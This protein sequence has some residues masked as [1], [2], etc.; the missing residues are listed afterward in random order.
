MHIHNSALLDAWYT[1]ITIIE[2]IIYNLYTSVAFGCSA[3]RTLVALSLQDDI[4]VPMRIMRRS[5]VTT[6]TMIVNKTQSLGI[7]LQENVNNSNCYDYQF[8]PVATH[9][10]MFSY[11][12][13]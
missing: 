5:T 10:M 1:L 3:S 11:L 13:L 4:A 12:F 8:V 2:I 6:A 9:A 7:Y